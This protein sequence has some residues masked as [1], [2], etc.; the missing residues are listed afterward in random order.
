MVKKKKLWRKT[1]SDSQSTKVAAEALKDQ[2]KKKEELFS[3]DTLGN[4]P[5]PVVYP[6]KFAKEKFPVSMSK[7]DYWKLKQIPIKRPRA[8]NSDMFDL[9]AD[10]GE[11]LQEKSNSHIPAVIK[12][13]PGLSYRP[14]KSD[15]EDI[16]QRVVEEEMI[17]EEEAKKHE[18]IINGY[19]V[20]END[21]SPEQSEDETEANFKNPPIKIKNL[22]NTQKNIKK[23]NKLKE[24]LKKVLSIERKTQKQLEKIP[25]IT[26]ELERLEKKYQ[27]LREDDLLH[28]KL[29]VE[30]EKTG[31]IVPKIRMGKFRYKK[32]ETLANINPADN[33]RKMNVKG[34][35]V[36]ER[37]D[38]FIRRKMVDLYKPKDKKLVVIK[39]NSN[40]EREREYTAARMAK[41][42]EKESGNISLTK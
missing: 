22:T 42:N 4:E 37:L 12:P 33:L 39:E 1:L 32:P 9:W 7:A 8:D 10:E 11:E 41:K 20:V 34:N 15:Q 16:I 30:L 5:G 40:N 36:E 6:D 18:E 14:E 2:S 28:K 25:Q 31:E 23:R 13:L 29:K 21:P 24:K 38:S 19:V 3:V 27:A 17:K 35:V 26:K